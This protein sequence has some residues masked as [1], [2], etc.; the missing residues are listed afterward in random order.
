MAAKRTPKGDKGGASKPV[1]ASRPVASKGINVKRVLS[2]TLRA[3]SPANAAKLDAAMVAAG[4]V[5]EETFDVLLSILGP[6]L[7][8]H[9]DDTLVRVASEKSGSKLEADMLQIHRSLGMA[10]TVIARHG[11]GGGAR[12]AKQFLRE[13]TE[14]AKKYDARGSVLNH[15]EAVISALR[16]IG[17][18][19]L[20]D[21]SDRYFP[22]YDGV[23]REVLR[24]ERAKPD[25]EKRV[26]DLAKRLPGI[27]APHFD[28]KRGWLPG[29]DFHDMAE[30]ACKVAGVDAFNVLDAPERMR[31]VRRRKRDA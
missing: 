25:F 31:E 23:A 26:S 16:D 14:L 22:N 7:R 13:V 4:D 1:E 27:F 3:L 15:G 8:S 24:K 5:D 29:T 11:D 10:I 17:Q 20:A 30:K 9:V 12:P 19:L 18:A 2:P 6:M 28:E 21:W